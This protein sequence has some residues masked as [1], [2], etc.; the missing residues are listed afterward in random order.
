[1][2]TW[3]KKITQ[4]KKYRNCLIKIG[5]VKVLVEFLIEFDT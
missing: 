4:E 3:M 5:A 1:M 2:W